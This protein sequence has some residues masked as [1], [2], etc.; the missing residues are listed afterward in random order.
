MISTKIILL[1][2]VLNLVSTV[3]S[4]HERVDHKASEKAHGEATYLGNEGV[5]ITGNG[6]KILFD[7]FFHNDYGYYQLVPERIRQAMFKGEKPYDNIDV[8]FISHAHGDHFSAV[9]LRQFMQ[10]QPQVKLVA[11]KQ[12]V[13]KL[14]ELNLTKNLMKRVTAVTLKYG[15]KPW[16]YTI[17]DLLVEAVRI[18]HSGWPGRAEVENIVFRVTFNSPNDKKAAADKL[19]IMHMGDADAN[20]SHYIP[21]QTFW[22]HRVTNTAFPPYWFFLSEQGNA[23][24]DKRINAK[25]AIGLH[26]PVKVPPELKATGKHFFSVVEEKAN[27]GM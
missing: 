19:T 26:V 15:E 4:A 3:V 24:L 1:V 5:M 17:D 23:I 2:L 11:P 6:K 9:D 13:D 16:F 22:Q 14:A 10:A 18:P 8:V 25:Q 12:A 21:Y 7:P 20:D 27:L